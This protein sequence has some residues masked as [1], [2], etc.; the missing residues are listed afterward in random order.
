MLHPD[1][2]YDATRIPDLVAPIEAGERDLK[3]PVVEDRDADQRQREQ[4]EVDRNTE[5]EHRLDDRDRRCGC[6]VSG[7]RQRDQGCNGDPGREKP[8]K[9]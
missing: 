9:N 3:R 8:E 2:Q 4:D 7:G 5:Y 6:R 1:Y